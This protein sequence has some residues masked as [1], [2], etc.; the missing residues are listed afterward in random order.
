M[1]Y[2]YPLILGICLAWTNCMGGRQTRRDLMRLV[3]YRFGVYVEKEMRE[4]YGR[5]G[6]IRE[7]IEG[8]FVVRQRLVG[9]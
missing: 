9:G 3:R 6:M 1:C 5:S 2:R 8:F 7:M 4:G